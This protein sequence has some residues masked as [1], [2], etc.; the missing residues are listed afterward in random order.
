MV[1]HSNMASLALKEQYQKISSVW[2]CSHRHRRFVE[3]IEN[4]VL[5]SQ[6][7]HIDNVV[8]VGLGSMEKDAMQSA[9]AANEP[10]SL[11]SLSINPPSAATKNNNAEETAHEMLRP[12][13][14]P[15]HEHSD[16]NRPLHKLAMLETTLNILRRRHIISKISFYDEGFTTADMSFL[17][18]WCHPISALVQT[19]FRPSSVFVNLLKDGTVSES[20]F[21]FVPSGWNTDPKDTLKVAQALC[22]HKP[23]LYIGH[24]PY[25]CPPRFCMS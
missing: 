11:A 18:D 16:H 14:G 8:C 9:S 3:F 24:M 5:P 2:E 23:A 22:M 6:D 20:T 1:R 13:P 12:V 17:H 10:L 21:F 25:E 4:N 19:K 15:G 7:V